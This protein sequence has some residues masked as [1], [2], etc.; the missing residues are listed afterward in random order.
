MD[1][2]DQLSALAAG[3][4]DSD[5]ARAVRAR[6]AGDPALRRQLARHEQLHAVLT[7]WDV[8]PMTDAQQD[9][10]DAAVTAALDDLA[11][12]PL[13]APGGAAVLGLS[14]LPD[15]EHEDDGVAA[16]RAGAHA[17]AGGAVLDLGAARARRR[18]WSTWASGLVA[19]AAALAVVGTLGTGLGGIGGSDGADDTSDIAAM[20]L[21]ADDESADFEAEDGESLS[22]AG[23]E[24]GGEAAADEMAPAEAAEDTADAADDG[25]LDDDALRRL[26]LLAPVVSADVGSLDAATVRTVA[27]QVPADLRRRGLEELAARTSAPDDV[28]GLL[29]E[30]AAVV[31]DLAREEIP[32]VDCIEPTLAELPATDVVL[33]VGG[34][35]Y[36]SAPGA[37]V[38]RLTIDDTGR[39]VVVTTVLESGSCDLL[40]EVV[41]QA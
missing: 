3:E 13:V 28:T 24:A 18:G 31:R 33:L 11:D 15:A 22:A 19:A 25:D 35:T 41:E 23:T 9:A 2:D 38:V 5:E 30:S 6:V 34:G 7:G 39:Q 1:L 10:L 27:D 20:E 32:A 29:A 21:D 40:A 14:P 37:V 12:G 17:A 36:D 26:P 4:L 8:P 16:A